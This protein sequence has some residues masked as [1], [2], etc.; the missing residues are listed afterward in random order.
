MAGFEIYH[1]N[2]SIHPTSWPN[3]HF[4]ELWEEPKHPDETHEGT[5][6]TWEQKGP[7]QLPGFLLL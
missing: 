7:S 6:K 2:P 4:S 3:P 1:L 5:R